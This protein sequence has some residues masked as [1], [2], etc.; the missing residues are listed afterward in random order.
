[1]SAFRI[2]MVGVSLGGG[3]EDALGLPKLVR[4]HRD[5]SVPGGLFTPAIHPQVGAGP[6]ELRQRELAPHL[7]AVIKG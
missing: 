3:D 5:K 7:D 1:M 4:A 2:T 6:A